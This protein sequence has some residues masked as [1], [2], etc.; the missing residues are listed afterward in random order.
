PEVW[1]SLLATHLPSYMLPH[2]FMFLAEFPHSP[3]GK[4]D[5]QALSALALDAAPATA[6]PTA[7]RTRHE[8]ILADIWAEVL[9][10]PGVD[11]HDTFF[12]LGGDSIRSLQV[13]SQAARAGLLLTARDVFHHQTIAA[14]AAV[15][16]PAAPA[17]EA[18]HH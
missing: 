11:V 9:G 18:L 7:P 6:V 14:L 8:Q 15:A 4:V 10:L 13:V 1:R 3:N 16:R 17:A 12:A 2:F 5:R